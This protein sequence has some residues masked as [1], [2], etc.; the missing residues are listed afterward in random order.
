M[1]GGLAR[2]GA[3]RL[4]LV[5]LDLRLDHVEV[6]DG[7]QDGRRVVERADEGVL[8]GLDVERDDGAVDVGE[9][10]DLGELVARLREVRAEARQLLLGPAHARLLDR[11]RSSRAFSSASFS[12]TSCC[13]VE[14]S[15]RSRSSSRL[16][17]VRLHLVRGRRGPSDRGLELLDLGLEGLGIDPQEELPLLDRVALLDAT[18]ITFPETAAETSTIVF[19]RIL[20]EAWMIAAR[21]L[22]AIACV[23]TSTAFFPSIRRTRTTAATTASPAE[24]RAIFEPLF[25]RCGSYS[26]VRRSWAP[27][28]RSPALAD[29]WAGSPQNADETDLR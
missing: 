21:S 10:V 15:R 22:F 2:L 26:D 16:L 29:S 6:G 14:V 12:D 27:A 25:N 20:P 19:G 9:D 28:R 18:S 24:V 3:H 13:F 1:L 8:A 17:H 5:D 11:R 4:G 23:S 7:E